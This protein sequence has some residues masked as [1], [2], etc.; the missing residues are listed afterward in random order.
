MHDLVLSRQPVREAV[1]AELAAWLRAYLPD[2]GATSGTA[3]GAG[4]DGTAGAD[5]TASMDGT[6]S[7]GRAQAETAA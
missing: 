1:F 2:P 4:T 7:A 5:G 3:A 6:D